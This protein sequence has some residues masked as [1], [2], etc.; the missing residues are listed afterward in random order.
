MRFCH[1]SNQMLPTFIIYWAH[2]AILPLLHQLGVVRGLIH[3]V[4]VVDMLSYI[5]SMNLQ[6]V[7]NLRWPYGIPTNN[8]WLCLSFSCVL[9]RHHPR[10]FMAFYCKFHPLGRWW[11]VFGVRPH[12]DKGASLCSWL[13]D[14]S[15]AA[16]LDLSSGNLPRRWFVVRLRENLGGVAVY[17]RD[18]PSN[19]LPNCSKWHIFNIL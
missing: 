12:L 7:C 18:W 5:Y 4:A 8:K 6:G 2:T 11:S 10:P 19:W 15:P 9:K 14:G 1:V 13:V 16:W 17:V 3:G